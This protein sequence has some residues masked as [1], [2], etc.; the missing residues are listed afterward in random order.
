MV[1]AFAAGRFLDVGELGRTI[2]EHHAILEVLQHFLGDFAT[3]THCVFAVHLIGRMHQAVGQLTV[4][5][6]QQQA[7]GVDIEATDIDPAAFFGARQTIEYGGAAFRVITGADLAIRLV[8]D[9][10]AANRAG[11]FFALEQTAIKSDGVIGIDALAQGRS[12]AVDLD[13]TFGDPG[14]DLAAR[15]QPK[16]GQDFLQFLACRTR[17]FVLSHL[18]HLPV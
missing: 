4:S 7:S 12:S 15:G 13:P 11:D 17:L 16:A 18:G 3:Y 10:H 6:E 9:Q 5:G 2:L 1:E 14:L 8:V